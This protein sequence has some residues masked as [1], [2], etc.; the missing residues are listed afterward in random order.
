MHVGGIVALTCD[1]IGD[2]Q[3]TFE[4]HDLPP[5]AMAISGT[6]LL[7]KDLMLRNTGSYECTSLSDHFHQSA[8]IRVYGKTL[9]AA[10]LPVLYRFLILALYKIDVQYGIKTMAQIQNAAN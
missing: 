4:Q 1:Y 9:F 6:K 7:V 5:N 2:L 3:W 8:L 10:S